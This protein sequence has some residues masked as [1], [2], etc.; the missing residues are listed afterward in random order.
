MASKKEVSGFDRRAFEILVREHHR[1]MMG[2]ALALVPR[3]DVAQDLVQDSFVTAYQKLDDFDVTRDFGKWVRGILYKKFQEWLRKHKERAT[4]PSVFSAV[5][6]QH[7]LWDQAPEKH[8]VLNALDRCLDELPAAMVEV[9]RMFYHDDLSGREIANRLE[10]QE[11][12]IRKRLERARA[13][14]ANC[15]NRVLAAEDIAL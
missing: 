14:L 4:D 15:I 2:F 6:H 8:A 9:V 1:R 7:S 10:A 5:D 3:R 13:N 12:T 11:A